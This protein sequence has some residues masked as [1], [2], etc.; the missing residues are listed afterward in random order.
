MKHTLTVLLAMLML[1][2]AVRASDVDGLLGGAPV[3]PEA[4]AAGATE[5]FYVY[6]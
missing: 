5:P 3:K 4:A 6:A 1:A 2:G